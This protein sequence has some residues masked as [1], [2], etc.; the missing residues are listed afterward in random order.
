MVDYKT[1]IENSIY[2]SLKLQFLCYE[3]FFSLCSVAVTLYCNFS[4][5][6]LSEMQ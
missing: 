3:I 4:M 5:D 2:K 1:D 6:S